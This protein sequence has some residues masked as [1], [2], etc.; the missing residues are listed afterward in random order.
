MSNFEWIYNSLL[1]TI[2]T[3]IQRSSKKNKLL[4]IWANNDWVKGLRTRPTINQTLRS[5]STKFPY[6]FILFSFL[7]FQNKKGKTVFFIVV[8]FCYDI[9]FC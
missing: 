4:P 6:L 9:C 3:Y 8:V 2:I 1:N 7:P 5:Q